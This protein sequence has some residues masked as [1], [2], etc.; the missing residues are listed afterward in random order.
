MLAV[1]LVGSVPGEAYAAVATGLAALI[2]SLVAWLKYRHSASGSV[3]T[4]DAGRLWDEAERVRQALRGELD[5]L[6]ADAR[7]IQQESMDLIRRVS[8]AEARAEEC[9]K[10]VEFQRLRI[11]ELE[12]LAR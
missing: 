12:A 6:R 3:D 9:E 10:L 2:G 4:T 1:V 7:R 8:V 5:E 11:A